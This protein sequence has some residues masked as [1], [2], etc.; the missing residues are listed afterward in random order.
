MSLGLLSEAVHSASCGKIYTTGTS[1]HYKP[2]DAS[3]KRQLSTR[4]LSPVSVLGSGRYRESQATHALYSG[5][6]FSPLK[7]MDGHRGEARPLISLR[8]GFL[9]IFPI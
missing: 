8:P 1:S 7:K 3:M 6:F 9:F 2:G 5:K 4:W